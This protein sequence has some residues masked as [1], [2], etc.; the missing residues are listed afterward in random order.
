MVEFYSCFKM[1]I[2]AAKAV[3]RVKVESQPSN[4]IGNFL[5]VST[6]SLSVF[7][8]TFPHIIA[9]TIFASDQINYISWPAWHLL[10]NR[11]F[12]FSV[13]TFE[14]FRILYYFACMASRTLMTPC[15]LLKDGSLSLIIYSYFS[16]CKSPLDILALSCNI[17]LIQTLTVLK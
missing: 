4:S 1:V 12:S 5:L 8:L 11:V 16:T 3:R 17:Q 6:V 14:N 7:P 9:P 13:V 10:T 15:P 2:W